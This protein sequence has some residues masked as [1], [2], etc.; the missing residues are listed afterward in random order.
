M[1]QQ[2]GCLLS[3]ENSERTRAACVDYLQTWLHH[4]YP[5]RLDIVG[6]MTELAANLEGQ[7]ELPRLSWKYDWIRRSFGWGPAKRAQL[8][9]PRMKWAM[10]RLWDRMLS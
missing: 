9:A 2:I 1:R 8:A 6:E 4:F 5:N 3:L 7:L 10:L